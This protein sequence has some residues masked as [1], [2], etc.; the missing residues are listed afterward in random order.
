MGTLEDEFDFLASSVERAVEV[1]ETGAEHLL[2]VSSGR[3]EILAKRLIVH[4]GRLLELVAVRRKYF[5]GIPDADPEATA[6]REVAI[7]EMR[8]H[9]DYTRGDLQGCLAWLDA[10]SDPVLDL[11]SRYLIEFFASQLVSPES[12]VTVVTKPDGSYSISV[13]DFLDKA[14]GG[15]TEK[16]EGIALVISI[17]RGEQQSGL[18]HTLI[19]HELGHAASRQ[20]GLAKQVRDETKESLRGGH[21]TA[22]TEVANQMKADHTFRDGVSS[23]LKK[24][25]LIEA[26]DTDRIADLAEE[27]L[28]AIA[29]ACI[30]EAMCDAFAIRLLGPTYL[31]AFAAI[32]GTSNLDDCDYVH[33]TARQR[34]GLMLEQLDL[35]GWDEVLKEKTPNI[36]TW[37]REKAKESPP[38]L[39]AIPSFGA[40]AVDAAASRVREVVADHVDNLAF[41]PKDFDDEVQKSIADLL[42][43]G[44]PPAQL[45]KLSLEGSQLKTIRRPEIILGSWLFAI[46]QEEGSLP[47]IA[48]AP[49]LPEL[50]SL[51]PKALEM[52]A[53]QRAWGEAT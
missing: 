21:A 51:L 50:S 25:E 13:S 17:P 3:G 24:E 19:V 38:S 14:L 11:G 10:A 35:A 43:V 31:Y 8:T 47:A 6:L 26:S 46:A 30:E 28:W 20:H 41:S 48:K 53:L 4:Y 22:T 29:Q 12:E 5:E 52:S 33:P 15:S 44:V 45:Q 18:L 2:E 37:F 36:D 27:F 16:E 1:Q 42:A 32:V 49:A 39:E 40:K 34:I 23:F 7:E 9:L